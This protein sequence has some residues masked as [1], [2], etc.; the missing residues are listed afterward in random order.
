VNYMLRNVSNLIAFLLF[1]FQFPPLFN[2]FIYNAF[3]LSCFVLPGT[4][5]RNTGV[6]SQSSR[7]NVRH[8]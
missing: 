6:L 8:F 1:E 7:I 4:R 3:E 5:Y 2:V